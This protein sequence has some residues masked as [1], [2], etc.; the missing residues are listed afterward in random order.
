MISKSCC[1]AI[2]ATLMHPTLS[3]AAPADPYAQLYELMVKSAKED[4]R[5]P[6]TAETA[7]MRSMQGMLNPHQRTDLSAQYYGQCVSYGM[8][9]AETIYGNLHAGQFKDARLN[10]C[11]DL[12]NKGDPRFSGDI[13]LFQLLSCMQAK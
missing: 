4:C 5:T 10:A 3:R 2:A 12:I 9:A 1:I 6:G 7:Q 11:L 8:Q 13:P